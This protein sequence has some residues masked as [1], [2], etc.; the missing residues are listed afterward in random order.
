VADLRTGETV[1]DLGSGGG[2]DVILSA[3]RVGETGIAY[4]GEH[5]FYFDIGRHAHTQFMSYGQT[6]IQED[7]YDAVKWAIDRGTADPSRIAALGWTRT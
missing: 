6:M 1:L 7:L 2:I 4:G 3:K 5:L